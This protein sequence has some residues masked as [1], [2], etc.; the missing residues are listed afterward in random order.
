VLSFSYNLFVQDSIDQSDFIVEIQDAVGLSNK[1]IVVRD[2]FQPSAPA[3]TPEETVELGWKSVV[4]SLSQY[5][6]KFIRLV[7][8][9]RNISP[10]SK[11]IWSY[12]EN[13]SVNDAP[14]IPLPY[15]IFLPAITR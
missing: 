14:S 5:R 13:I 9:N 12:V 1:S 15:K 2:G 8:S 11:G 6:G 7:I 3:E 4:Y 10:D